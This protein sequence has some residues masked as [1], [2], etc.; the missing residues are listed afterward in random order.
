MDIYNAMMKAADH[1]ERNPKLFD[2]MESLVRY[3]SFPMCVIG[4]VASFMDLGYEWQEVDGIA[5]TI[6]GVSEEEFY[7]RMDRLEVRPFGSLTLPWCS[8]PLLCAS[9]LRQYAK[10]FH[11]PDPLP[12]IDI[13]STVRA[14]FETPET[15][16][17]D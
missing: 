14:L 6:L 4:R 13:P 1:I 8:N 2:F 15:A 5:P 11:A 7:S 9:L 10:I 17:A 3:P 16:A 12:F